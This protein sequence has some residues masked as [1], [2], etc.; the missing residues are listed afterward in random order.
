MNLT[1][2][3]HMLTEA[4]LSS[5]F[6]PRRVQMSTGLFLLS[7]IKKASRMQSNWPF[8]SQPA[9]VCMGLQFCMKT[10]FVAQIINK[11]ITV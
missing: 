9:L 4:L 5:V 6:K 11:N 3:A 2:D 1:N 10:A 7:A 8:D